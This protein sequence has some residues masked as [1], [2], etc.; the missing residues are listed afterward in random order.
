MSK[1]AST[2][3]PSPFYK[4][5]LKSLKLQRFISITNDV[6]LH[7]SLPIKRTSYRYVL[8]TNE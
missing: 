8:Q 5:A 1:A 6:V 2:V 7:L 4:T 3:Q